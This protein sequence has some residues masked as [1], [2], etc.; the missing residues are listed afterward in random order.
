MGQRP[1][2]EIDPG[3]E[4]TCLYGFVHPA[5]GDTEWLILLRKLPECK[6]ELQQ[7]YPGANIEVWSFDEYRIGLKPIIRRIWAT[8]GQRPIAE[9]DPGYEW[10]CLYGFVHPATGD[11]EWL[12]LPRVNGDGFNQALAT[13]AQQ[14]GAGPHKRIFTTWKVSAPGGSANLSF[15][16]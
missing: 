7:R 4:W 14:G 11:T 16:F 5:T 12:I 10:T 6:A 1:I 8:V 15:P 13:F 2:A 3:Y 9:I